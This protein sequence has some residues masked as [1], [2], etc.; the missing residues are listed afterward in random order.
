[1]HDLKVPP[2]PTDDDEEPPGHGPA[3][4][5][6][7]TTADVGIGA[8]G[9]PPSVLFAQLGEGLTDLITDR[10]RVRKGE[11]R[12]VQVRS[13]SV[14]G[15]VVAFLGALV[16]LFDEEGFVG[17]EFTVELEGDPPRS[18]LA[19]VQGE[20]FDPGRH[21][22]RVQVK[23]ITLHQLEADLQRGVAHVVVDI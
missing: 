13:S 1:L 11:R 12:S 6:F 8:R 7:G 14:E 16:A 5:K 20:E 10:R 17:K 22:L 18:L 9:K 3:H 15:L 2:L 23:A 4:W 19:T 21:P